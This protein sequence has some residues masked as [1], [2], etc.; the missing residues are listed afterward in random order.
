MK[1][2]IIFGPS[3]VGK[4]T[5][6]H[7]LQ[8]LTGIKLFHNHVTLDLVA[9]YFDWSDPKFKK[10]VAEF[11]TRIIE[12]VATSN[13]PGLI[14]TYV[15][16]LNMA[17]DK[18]EIDKYASIFEKV[19]AEVCFVE[20]YADQKNRI[21]RNKTE[22]RI[23]MKSTKRDVIHTEKLLLA[24]DEKFIL[25]TKDDFFYPDRHIKID[26]SNLSPTETVRKIVQRFG[27]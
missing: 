11:R 27:L 24:D 22:F 21:E 18:I 16:A 2:I 1:L 12:E 20:L 3:A 17:K 10:L 23:K 13:L 14:F 6:G 26:N 19:G 8:K 5:V 4:M 7:E 15:W 25:N 9:Q